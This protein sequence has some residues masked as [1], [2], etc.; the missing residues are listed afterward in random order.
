MNVYFLEKMDYL[1]NGE[2]LKCNFVLFGASRRGHPAAAVPDAAT[3]HATLQQRSQ[4][5]R[6]QRYPVMLLIM[7]LDN[8]L[9]HVI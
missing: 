7:L 8:L 3:A 4:T 5:P 1:K 9:D 6:R 2:T